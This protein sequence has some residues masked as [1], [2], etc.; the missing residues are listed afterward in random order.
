MR[1][2]YFLIVLL[3]TVVTGCK[4]T[5]G[6][7]VCL[8]GVPGGD[9]Y[10]LTETM[11]QHI[12]KNY[13][14]LADRSADRTK[15]GKIYYVAPGCVPSFTFYEI[16]EPSDIQRIEELARQSLDIAGIERVHLNFYE[17][18]NWVTYSANGGGHRGHEK[19]IK[20]IT[21]TKVK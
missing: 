1:L 9:Q 20:S 6:S 17:K 3:G 10:A 12:K 5:H 13:P 7:F 15:Q 21:V 18:Q 4:R 8:F 11:A 19:T 14:A 16:V 2:S